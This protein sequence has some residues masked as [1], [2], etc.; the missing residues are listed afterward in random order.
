MFS[1]PAG[2]SGFCG[3]RF[4]TLTAFVKAHF[5]SLRRLAAVSSPVRGAF[6]GMPDSA[7]CGFRGVGLSADLPIAE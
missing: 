2:Q 5:V 6:A 1:K 7:S 3:V 4:R